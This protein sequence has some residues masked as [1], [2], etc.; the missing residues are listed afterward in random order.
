[1]K[2]M[3]A[4]KSLSGRPPRL[5]KKKM[6]LSAERKKLLII[7]AFKSSDRSS[8]N[9]RRNYEKLNRPRDEKRL[10]LIVSKSA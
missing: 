6:M 4:L 7:S 3:R 2:G 8:T 5:E 1:M 10:M 9:R